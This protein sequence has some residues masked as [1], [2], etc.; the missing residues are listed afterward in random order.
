MFR[1][2]YFKKKGTGSR[3]LYFKKKERVQGFISQ[4]KGR[5]GWVQGFIFSR[6][7]F[8]SSSSSSSSTIYI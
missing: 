3:I 5:G 6:I 8:K 2:L 1:I 4:K 7:K